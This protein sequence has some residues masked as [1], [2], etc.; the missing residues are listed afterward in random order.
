[1]KTTKIAIKLFL[2]LT[3]ITGLIYP[4][5]ITGVSQLIFH[6]NA[7]GS[8]IIKNNKLIGSE[9]IGQQFIRP[10]FFWGR[11][12]AIGNNPMPSGGSNLSPVG[13]P[14]REQFNARLDTIMKYHGKLPIDSIPKDLLFASA[15]GVD[16]HISPEADYFQ[17]SRVANYRNF[18]SE[19]RKELNKLIGQSV[20]KPDLLIL[21]QARVNVLKLNVKLMD[22]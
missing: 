2:V 8:M 20:E 1:M 14:F 22:L 17:A 18:N 5:A 9:L 19:Q 6:N 3:I 11:P 21:G 12:S 7:N 13:L 15:S 4:L 16:P 10:D